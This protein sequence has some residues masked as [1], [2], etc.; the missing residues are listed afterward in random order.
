MAVRHAGPVWALSSPSSQAATVE[1]APGLIGRI[2]LGMKRAGVR[3]AGNPHAAYDVAEAGNGVKGR[4]EAPGD[5]E[6][7]RPT[8]TPR[9]CGYRASFRPYR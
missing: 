8:A 6:S 5:G 9:P 7:L 2:T 1:S 4:T 3:S